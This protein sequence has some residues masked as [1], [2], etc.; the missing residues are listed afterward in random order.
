MKATEKIEYILI[1][2]PDDG[3]TEECRVIIEAFRT[4]RCVIDNDISDVEIAAIQ[5]VT[6]HDHAGACV[7]TTHGEYMDEKYLIYRLVGDCGQILNLTTHEWVPFD[8]LN[9]TQKQQ[10]NVY[11]VYGVDSQLGC[12]VIADDLINDG[13]TGIKVIPIGYHKVLVSISFSAD[14]LMD[15]LL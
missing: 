13:E 2:K 3:L 12:Q 4:E 11:R 15:N 7:G 1:P 5:A 14:D 10:N 8:I 6:K 9:L